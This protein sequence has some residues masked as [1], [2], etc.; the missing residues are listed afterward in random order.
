MLSGFNKSS[1]PSAVPC[2]PAGGS[3]GGALV[4]NANVL[5]LNKFYQAIRVINVKRAFSLLCREMAEVVHIETSA[6]GESLWQ[7][8]WLEARTRGGAAAAPPA[9]P[10]ASVQPEARRSIVERG[11]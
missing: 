8:R 9:A 11:P 2:P 1:D 5:V 7:T 6:E 3:A 4:L 10:L